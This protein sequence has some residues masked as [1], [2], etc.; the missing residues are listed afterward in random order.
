MKRIFPLGLFA[1]LLIGCSSPT[2]TASTQKVNP[3]ETSVPTPIAQS[4]SSPN[5]AVRRATPQ[6]Q[7]VYRSARFSF[8][9]GYLN[10]YIVDPSNENRRPKLN[11]TLQGTIDIWKSADFEAIK[12]Q[13]VQGGELPPNMSIN[14]HS[15]PNQRPLSYWKDTLSIGSRDARAITVGGQNA[16]AYSSTG[17]YEFDNVLLSSPDGRR[18]IHLN[19]GYMDTSDLSRQAFQRVVSSFKFDR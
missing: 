2:S 1:L 16:L 11:E 4:T 6:T 10:G 19:V 7:N 17:L 12:S 3:V 8:A 5:P 18:V 9:F 14:V 13:S 15:N